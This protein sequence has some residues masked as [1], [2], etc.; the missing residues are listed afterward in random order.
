MPPPDVCAPTAQTPPDHAPL[1][2]QMP[3][4]FLP[5]R[6]WSSG[7]CWG[8]CCWSPRRWGGSGCARGVFTP[9]WRRSSPC[10]T[11]TTSM[12][13]PPEPYMGGDNK[14]L[15]ASFCLLKFL[16]K[17]GRGRPSPLGQSRR[18]EGK[19]TVLKSDLKFPSADLQ[20]CVNHTQPPRPHP[21]ISAVIR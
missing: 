19:P 18:E 21:I 17:P 14:R 15:E 16:I 20:M 2:L 4:E 7:G 11:F 6:P 5:W 1:P 10:P 12:R 13:G 9:P 8:S 3:P